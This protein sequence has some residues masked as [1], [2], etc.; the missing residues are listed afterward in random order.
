MLT[1][2]LKL[3]NKRI[4]LHS[5]EI[6]PTEPFLYIG[7]N[8]TLGLEINISPLAPKTT[9]E[10]LLRTERGTLCYSYR[11]DARCQQSSNCMLGSNGLINYLAYRDFKIDPLRVC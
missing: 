8:V 4:I 2:C 7:A 1:V 3:R 5:H 11:S 6:D 9:V 10:S